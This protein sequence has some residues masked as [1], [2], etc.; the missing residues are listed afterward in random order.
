MI[1]RKALDLLIG[2]PVDTSYEMVYFE[3]LNSGLA[4]K[5][6]GILNYRVELSKL[7]NVVS[8]GAPISYIGSAKRV[9][10]Y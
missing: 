10:S 1:S 5:V 9:F 4:F 7:G 3:L 8:H 2:N 6:L